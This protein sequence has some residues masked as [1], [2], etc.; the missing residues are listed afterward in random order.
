VLLFWVIFTLFIL[1]II[2]VDLRASRHSGD[3]FQPALIRSCIFVALAA[4]FALL[5]FE[6][7]GRA[8]ALQFVT[9]YV[10]ELSLSIDNLFVFLVIFRYFN[11]SAENQHKVL[12]AG[13]LGAL[14]MR[15]IFILLGVSLFSR[16]AW[17]I[18]L[19]GALLVYSGF[20]LFWQPERKV[21]PD[22]NI[23]VRVLKRLLP[24]AEDEVDARFFFR[25]ARSNEK[26]YATP[27]LVA[28]LVIEAGDLL[29][30]ADSVPAVLS[31]TLNPMIVFTSN[32]LAILGLRSM[33]FLLAGVM[34]RFRYL[35]HGVSLVL[36]F[37]G[38]KM[39]G[40]HY[41][42]LPTEWTLALILLIVGTSIL[43][44]LFSPSAQSK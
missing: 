20:K 32:M 18:Y 16:F 12:I 22:K 23:F 10:I 11:L 24:I 29:L 28:L 3:A 4:V 33:Y 40:S 27:M 36:L 17:L 7:H 25:N 41:F 44:S 31:V 39:V 26:L 38:L 34:Q 2:V 30:A 43:V 5:V 9:C 19:F 6:W 1:V 14:V 42:H 37:V 13:I 8:Y 21:N 15:G 35:H